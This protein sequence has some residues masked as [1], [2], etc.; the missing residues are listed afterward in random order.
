M[1]DA[2]AVAFLG[3]GRVSP[4]VG[5]IGLWDVDTAIPPDV[6]PSG[7]LHP[8]RKSRLRHVASAETALRLRCSVTSAAGL[9]IGASVAVDAVASIDSS[10]ALRLAGAIET[11]AAP[12]V[13]AEADVRDVVL[14]MLL[15]AD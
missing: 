9:R 4:L 3:I 14:E 8:G 6:F 1:L 15:L 13:Q 12:G 7:G 11:G 5:R 10:A 2:G